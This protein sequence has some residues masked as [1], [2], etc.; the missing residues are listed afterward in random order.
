M[1]RLVHHAHVLNADREAGGPRSRPTCA[2]T[3]PRSRTHSYRS[4]ER[5]WPVL[6]VDEMPVL[7][8]PPRTQRP[9]VFVCGTRAVATPRPQPDFGSRLPAEA[10]LQR[11][12]SNLPADCLQ[13]DAALVCNL[14]GVALVA[15]LSIRQYVTLTSV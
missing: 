9:N 12:P 14:R 7:T 15:T 6:P 1:D 3:R 8:R 5:K 11:G 10:E 4:P 2:P 13:L